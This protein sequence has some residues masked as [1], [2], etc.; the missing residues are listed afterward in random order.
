LPPARMIRRG[1]W[2]FIHYEGY[3][4]QL[5]DLEE[6]PGEWY[7]LGTDPDFAE[8]RRQLRE[9]A[10]EGWS[11]QFLTSE[12]QRRRSHHGLLHEWFSQV[13]PDHPLQWKASPGS[14]ELCI[15]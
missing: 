12:L 11:A 4:P 15:K 14:N 13:R 1:R 2:K 5:Y 8:T 3:E 9:R 6:D 10:L 7:D